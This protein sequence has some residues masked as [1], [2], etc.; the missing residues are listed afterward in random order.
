MIKTARDRR[1]TRGFATVGIA[2]S[3]LTV[4]ACGGSSDSATNPNVVH[5][6]PEAPLYRMLPAQ[7]Q[8]KTINI[9]LDPSFG[10]LNSVKPGTSE[11]D[12]L[13]ADLAKAIAEELGMQIEL[14]PSAFAQ[15]V[16][17][18][19]S[20]RFDMSMSAVTDTV[21][22][23]NTVDFVD[24]LEVKQA[25]F[26]QQGNPKGVSPSLDSAC[27]LNLSVVRGTPD[28]DL[29]SKISDV[30]LKAGKEAPQAVSI[31]NVD[32]GYL[33]IESGRIDAMIRENSSGRSGAKVERIDVENGLKYYFGAIFSK[34]ETALRD[35]W[36]AGIERII[37][38]GKYASILEENDKSAI[39][40]TVPG[41]NL[42]K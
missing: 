19:G 35:T 8:D 37:E 23:Q 31:E 10:V 24:Y 7:Y 22:R 16:L 15:I 25:L 3:L 36:L 20:G 14:V 2:L 12:G 40:L 1:V 5:V 21:E 18:V 33:A 13:N 32:A 4:T 11:F 29:F 26:V 39:A 6:D 38:S 42:Q 17:G 41:I 27:G 30:C 9:A 28:E 34:D